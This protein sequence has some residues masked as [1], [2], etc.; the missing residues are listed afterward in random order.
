MLLIGLPLSFVVLDHYFVDEGKAAARNLR[1]KSTWD[2]WN[3]NYLGYLTSQVDV[4]VKQD[5]REVKYNG[6]IIH[7]SDHFFALYLTDGS[8][9]TVVLPVESIVERSDRECF[10]FSGPPG[11]MRGTSRKGPETQSRA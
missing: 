9:S 2:G 11:V 6:C 8:R 5:E 7:V 4:R 1:E 10:D 3:L